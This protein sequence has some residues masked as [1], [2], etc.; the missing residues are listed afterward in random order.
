MPASDLHRACGCA[1]YVDGKW[2]HHDRDWGRARALL[3]LGE[4]AG[5][6]P[7]AKRLCA[8]KSRLGN[9]PLHWA[10][11]HNAHAPEEVLLRILEVNTQAYAAT[12]RQGRLPL[13][14]AVEEKAEESGT[15]DE[16]KARGVGVEIEEGQGKR[17]EVVVT[18]VGVV[19]V[20]TVAIC[21]VVAVVDIAVV[22]LIH[23]CGV[24]TWQL[25]LLQKL[26]PNRPYDG[27]P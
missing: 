9:L 24:V 8:E 13:D 16:G 12:D 6:H 23:L 19:V 14:Y 18:H 22:V 27:H 21:A 1:K 11:I 2:K 7:R 25:H 26:H 15:R 3:G 4:G 20:E 17:M 5:P 10:L